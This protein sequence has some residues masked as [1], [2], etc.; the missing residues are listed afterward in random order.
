MLF[1][2]LSCCFLLCL[3]KLLP[4]KLSIKSSVGLNIRLLCLR[5][6]KEYKV[7]SEIREAM[8]LYEISYDVLK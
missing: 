6:S 7:L 4:H 1:S 3:E 8:E 2:K 5:E